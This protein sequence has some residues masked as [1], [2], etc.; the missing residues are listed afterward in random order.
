S[1]SAAPKAPPPP[2]PPPPP[3]GGGGGDVL[4][5][6]ANVAKVSVEVPLMV[7]RTP[8]S[9]LLQSVI[10]EGTVRRYSFFS[11]WAILVEAAAI[12]P[13]VGAAMYSP[14]VKVGRR[15]NNAVFLTSVT[16]IVK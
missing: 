15:V 9:W 13:S 6:R 5:Q 7:T 16:P 1:S 14:P 4:V 3:G 12:S 2:P 10:V 8:T 11:L